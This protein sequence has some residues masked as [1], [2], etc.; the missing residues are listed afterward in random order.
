MPGHGA[1][2]GGQAAGAGAEDLDLAAL[3]DFQ[4]DAACAGP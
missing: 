4:G 1:G 2:S 3:L